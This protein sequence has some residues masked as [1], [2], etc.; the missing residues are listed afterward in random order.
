MTTPDN[1]EHGLKQLGLDEKESKVYLAA[2]QLGP[3][4]V[5]KISQRS[6]VPRATTYLVLDSLREKGLI[7]TYQKGKKTYFSAESPHRL[8]ELISERLIKAR[9]QQEMVQE[10]IPLL[11]SVGQFPKSTRPVVRYYEGTKA[12]HAF[13]RDSLSGV[14]G[15]VIGLAHLD[16]AQETLEKADF[17]IEKVRKRRAQ[18][19]IKSRLIYTTKQGPIEGYSTAE[20]QARYIPEE[21]FPFE[22]D[23]SIRGNQIFFIPYGLPLRGVAIQDDSI[24][25]TMRH[26]FELIWDYTKPNS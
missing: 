7:T 8:S 26:V 5:Q 14:G 24:A 10:L 9:Q 4:P 18:L 17:P 23:I 21:K 11:D 6:V 19:N 13:I 3:A 22:A 2:L 25:N 1:L 20:R 16:R 12:V 15:D